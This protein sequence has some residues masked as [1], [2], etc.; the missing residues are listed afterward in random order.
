MS[1]GQQK[2]KFSKIINIFQELLVSVQL[3]NQVLFLVSSE[4]LYCFLFEGFLRLSDWFNPVATSKHS[5]AE[6]NVGS[7][8]NDKSSLSYISYL[9]YLSRPFYLSYLFFIAVLSFRYTIYPI[10][11]I[12]PIYSILYL[13][14]LLDILS[15]RKY[16]PLYGPSLPVIQLELM[17]HWISAQHVPLI[18]SMQVNYFMFSFKTPIWM[19]LKWPK[20]VKITPD[21][22]CN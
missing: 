19:K 13:S 10:C 20:R 17:I 14:Y 2:A 4:L 12:C 11:S 18:Y 21:K 3:C 6:L 1:I 22:F 7:S 15:T 16:G 9:P 8:R 5:L